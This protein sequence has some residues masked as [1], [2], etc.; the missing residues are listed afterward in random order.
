MSKWELR[1]DGIYEGELKIGEC[2]HFRAV[3]KIIHQHNVFQDL[4]EAL[5]DLVAVCPCQN[6]CKP[7]DMSCAT[8][9]AKNALKLAK[10]ER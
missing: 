3:R 6:G 10:E 2:H 5:E 4:V 1:E 8:N 7:T 9:K